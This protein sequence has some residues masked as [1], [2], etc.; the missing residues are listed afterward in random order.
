MSLFKINSIERPGVLLHTHV[1]Y[2]NIM[3]KAGMH[4]NTGTDNRITSSWGFT[5]LQH[6]PLQRSWKCSWQALMPGWF[7]A[8]K[9]LNSSMSKSGHDVVT[10]GFRADV[11]GVL[12]LSLFSLKLNL[13]RDVEIINE[14]LR[15]SKYFCNQ[16]T[17]EWLTHR[18]WAWQTEWNLEKPTIVKKVR[19]NKS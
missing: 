2:V 16:T 5:G 1:Q 3:E 10:T 9:W 12:L 8:A 4:G 7:T 11:P 17:V 18:T 13:S 19:E 14:I 6:K 15:F